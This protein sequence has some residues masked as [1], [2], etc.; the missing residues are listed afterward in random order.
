MTATHW[1]N[2]DYA[3]DELTPAKRYVFSD[4]GLV[5]VPEYAL[6]TWADGGLKSSANDIFDRLDDEDAEQFESNYNLY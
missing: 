1:V 5:E 3:A 4:G 6:A 2:A